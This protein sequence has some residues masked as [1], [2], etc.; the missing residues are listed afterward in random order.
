MFLFY[1][2]SHYLNFYSATDYIEALQY[3][4]RG[5]FTYGD[6]GMPGANSC[7]IVLDW[8]PPLPHS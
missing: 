1:L 5:L 8:I 7:E 4:D 2:D 6:S 3:W